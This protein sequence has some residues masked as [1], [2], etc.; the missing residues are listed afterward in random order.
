MFV[1][2]AH[3]GFRSGVSALKEGD[4]LLAM[5][6]IKP[7]ADEN[8]L[9]A[10]HIVGQMHAFGLGVEMDNQQAQKW[11]ECI[12]INNCIDG[13]SEYNIA[14]DFMNGYA[15]VKDAEK[16]KYWMIKSSDKGFQKAK[17]WLGKN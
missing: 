3:E 5:E 12:D 2:Q 8:N 11:F 13:K 9:D 15:G 1:Y 14:L 6:K 10:R 7:Y 4:Y 17:D 16:S